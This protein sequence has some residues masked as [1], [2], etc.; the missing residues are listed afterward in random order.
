MNKLIYETIYKASSI[1]NNRWFIPLL[2]LV[3][4]SEIIEHTYFKLFWIVLIIIKLIYVNKYSYYI[5]RQNRF[6]TKPGPKEIDILKIKSIHK[7]KFFFFN[8]YYKNKNKIN[9]HYLLSI[10]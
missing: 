2:I 7:R 1:F 3:S 8:K 4:I 5:I 6:I 9:F 10:L